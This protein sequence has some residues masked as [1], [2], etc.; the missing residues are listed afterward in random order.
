LRATPA[1]EVSTC[2]DGETGRRARLRIWCRK[3]CGFDSLSSHYNTSAGQAF[4]SFVS[5]HSEIRALQERLHYTFREPAW[6]A[7]ALT[8]RSYAHEKSRRALRAPGPAPSHVA[9]VRYH[10]NERLEFLGDAVLA[11]AASTLLF[12]AFPQATEGELSKRR[13]EVVCEPLLAQ[14]AVDIELGRALRLGKGE[15]K[16]GGTEKPRLLASALEACLGAIYLDGGF[17]AALA[18]ASRLLTPRMAAHS[19][20]ATD[21]KSRLQEFAQAKLQATPTYH[22]THADGPAHARV[23]TVQVRVAG[24]PWGEAT[25]ATKSDAEQQA[26]AVAWETRVDE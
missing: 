10:D 15:Q 23:F 5:T 19:P 25:A 22:V 6:L 18:V 24:V 7:Q 13:A 12:E 21:H 17:D 8:H 11:L 3:A 1:L 14:I 16:T 4:S 20:G 9:R 26:A 2:E